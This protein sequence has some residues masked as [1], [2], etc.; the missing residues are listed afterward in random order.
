[1][2]SEQDGNLRLDIIL[3]Q[4]KKFAAVQIFQFVPYAYNQITPVHY[5]TNGEAT[6]LSLFLEKC[7]S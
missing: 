1:M 2:K 6:S 5:Y 4:D 7:K 3:S